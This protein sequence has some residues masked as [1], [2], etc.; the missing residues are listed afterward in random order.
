MEM[1]DKFVA[2]HH[3]VLHVVLAPTAGAS[4]LPDCRSDDWCSSA[5]TAG[6]QR[7]DLDVRRNGASAGAVAYRERI[8][9]SLN[10]ASR[11]MIVGGVLL[12]LLAAI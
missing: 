7:L 12:G 9:A 5:R 8:I 11:V 2:T 10:V 4:V 6:R 1:I 3:R